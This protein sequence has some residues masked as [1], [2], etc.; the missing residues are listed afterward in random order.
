MTNTEVGDVEV[1]DDGIS[2]MTSNG[3]FQSGGAV[4]CAGGWTNEILKKMTP[5]MEPLPLKTLRVPIFYFK[6]NNFPEYCVTNE[7]EGELI[8]A[9]PYVD[10]PGLVKVRMGFRKAQRNTDTTLEL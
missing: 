7:S 8:Y 5:P 1:T 10:H 2:V 4:I 9:I 6:S 3:R